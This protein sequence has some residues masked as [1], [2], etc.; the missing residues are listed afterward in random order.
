MLDVPAGWVIQGDWYV[1]DTTQTIRQETNCSDG[2]TKRFWVAAFRMTERETTNAAYSRCVKE[3]AC[4]GPDGESRVAWDDPSAARLPVILSP[5][6]AQAFC[7]HYGGDLPSAA[8]WD[9]AAAGDAIDTFGIAQLTRAWLDC[10]YGRGGDLCA[11][12]Q[13]QDPFRPQFFSGLRDV[14]SAPWDVGPFGHADLY[15]NAQEWVRTPALLPTDKDFCAL[16]DGGP[17][18]MSYASEWT[19]HEVHQLGAELGVPRHVSNA[20]DSEGRPTAGPYMLDH[21]IPTSTTGFRCAFP[22]RG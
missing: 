3:G 19:R 12:L 8:E 15:G 11:A 7:K 5:T 4:P 10:Y 16:A 21:D 17:D 2:Q 9:R 13:A 14:Q 20:L 18:P 22:P 6:L 1:D